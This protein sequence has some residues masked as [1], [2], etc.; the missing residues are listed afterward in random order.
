MQETISDL[1]HILCP[2]KKT[3]LFNESCLDFV[4]NLNLDDCTF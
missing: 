4:R 3:Q 2:L 1:A